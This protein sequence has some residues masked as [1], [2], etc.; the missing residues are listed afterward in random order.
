MLG[1]G[2]PVAIATPPGLVCDHCTRISILNLRTM[3]A[4]DSG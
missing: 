2:R 4:N 3:Y 1:A